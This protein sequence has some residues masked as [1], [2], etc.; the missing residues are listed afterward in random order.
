MLCFSFRFLEIIYFILF[1]KFES[2]SFLKVFFFFLTKKVG[3]ERGLRCEFLLL[4]Y[5][6]R[7]LKFKLVY[8]SFKQ[9]FVCLL[10]RLGICAILALKFEIKNIFYLGSIFL[11]LYCLFECENLIFFSAVFMF[12]SIEC[13]KL[14]TPKYNFSEC[15]C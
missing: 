1:L 6:G 9:E 12:V 4:P 11:D 14:S 7:I 2:K 8:H 5:S 15:K 13:E 10:S 3:G